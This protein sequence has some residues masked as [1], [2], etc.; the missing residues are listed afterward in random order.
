MSL[1]NKNP[2]QKL[3]KSLINYFLLLGIITTTLLSLVGNIGWNICLELLS[4]F[5]LQYLVISM[6]L[7]GL[8]LLTR[9]KKLIL[10]G[11]FCIAIILTEIAPWYIPHAG[12]G[13]ENIEKT[14]IFLANVGT[15]NQS[16]SKVISLVREEGPDVAVFIEVSDAWIKQLKSLDNILPYSVGKVNSENI[17]LVVFSQRPLE[18]AS[19][20]FFENT[21]EDASILG[22]LTIN[23]QVVSLIAT[24]PPPPVRPVWFHSRNKQLEEISQYVQQLKTPVLMVGDLN[25]TMWSPYYKRFV[26]QTG[27][28][29]ARQGFG[30]LP[31]W[32]TKSAFSQ[33]P[34]ALS[35]LLSIPIDHY[36]ISP[37]IKVV[38]IRTG[39]NV[40]SEHR[41]L[42]T[43]LVISEKK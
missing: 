15:G 22:N 27:L 31:S 28:H 2:R 25:I 33:I 13:K 32:P 24:H 23:G 36:L 37:G 5:K 4:H 6:L 3:F 40:G 10:V 35:L 38:N 39:P 16:Y 29:N 17:G 42:I 11:L 14:R 21:K 19:I 7:F 9:K 1:I 8:L 20:H 12:V 26:R 34:P 43:D 30:I 41:P 18:N